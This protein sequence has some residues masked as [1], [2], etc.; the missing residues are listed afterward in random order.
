MNFSSHSSP[1]DDD[2]FKKVTDDND[3]KTVNMK[4]MKKVTDIGA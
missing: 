3:H 2:S 1:S 4:S